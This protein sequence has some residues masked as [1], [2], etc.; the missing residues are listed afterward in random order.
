M[1]DSLKNILDDVL[2]ICNE[3]TDNCNE[4]TD[5]WNIVPDT[6]MK[7]RIWIS[8]FESII[9]ILNQGL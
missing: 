9:I 6:E 8:K 1:E 7:L 2:P 4:E 3:K 5:H